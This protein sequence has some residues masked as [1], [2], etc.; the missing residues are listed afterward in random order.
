MF[1]SSREDQK[2]KA[3][4]HFGPVGS[5]SKKN[6]GNSSERRFVAK[7]RAIRKDIDDGLNP[8]SSRY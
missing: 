3:M 2:S 7:R 8:W 5:E 6:R 1:G 4:A